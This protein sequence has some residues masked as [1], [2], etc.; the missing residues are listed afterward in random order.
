M[1]K[2]ISTSKAPKAIGPYNQ[3]IQAGNMLFISGQIPLESTTG[4]LVE[5]GIKEQT[6]QVLKNIEGILNEAGFSIKDVVK[7]TCMLKDMNHFKDM[8]E[9]YAEFFV[10]EE[11]ARATFQVGMLPMDVLVEI[12]AI[13]YKV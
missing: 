8:N 11:P 2:I 6:R 4:K 9:I 10:K 12:D 1:K 3:A 13:A 7:T 5:G